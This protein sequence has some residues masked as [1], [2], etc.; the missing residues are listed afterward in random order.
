VDL[1][2]QADDKESNNRSWHPNDGVAVVG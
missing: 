2:H 1:V